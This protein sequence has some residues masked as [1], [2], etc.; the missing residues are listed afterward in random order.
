MSDFLGLYNFR[1]LNRLKRK[2]ICNSKDITKKVEGNQLKPRP[3]N[4]SVH[5]LFLMAIKTC[6]VARSNA[7][8]RPV[9]SQG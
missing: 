4:Q 3:W 6:R 1:G 5:G 8:N 7:T 2:E 9:R